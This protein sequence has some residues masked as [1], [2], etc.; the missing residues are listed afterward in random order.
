M[1]LR[2]ELR[3][4]T[5]MKTGRDRPILR[6]PEEVVAQIKSSTVIV[7]LHGVVLELLK[8]ALDAKATR[9]EVSVDFTRG[10]CSVED[11]GLGIAPAEFRPDGGLGKLYCTSKYHAEESYLGCNGTFLASLAAVSLMT[12]ASRH[13]E[14]RSHNMMTFHHSKSIDRQLPAPPQHEMYEKHGTRVTV[15]NLFGN[16]P[17]R[18]KQRAVLAEQRTEHDRL[19]ET[20]QREVVGLLLSWRGQVSMKVRDTD[21][22]TSFS[23]STTAHSSESAEPRSSTLSYMLNVLTQ[24]NY[25]L[26]DDWI[27]WVPTAASTSAIS[28]KGAISLS[29]APSKRVQFISL[30]IRPLSIEFG[31]NELYD[32]VNR[33]FSQ[34][35]FGTVEEDVAV[36]EHEKVR[37]QG[38]KRFKNDGY[39][40]RQ[41]TARKGVDRFPMF[42]LRI[43]SKNS[44]KSGQPGTHFMETDANLQSVM[45]VLREMI[46]QWLSV[47]HFRPRK[48]RS[49]RDA[50]T[51]GNDTESVVQSNVSDRAVA[52]RSRSS[53]SGGSGRRRRKR[54]KPSAVQPTPERTQHRAFAEWSRVKSGKAD[55]F[56]NLRT[57]A[58]S[59]KPQNPTQ[60]PS[61]LTF[62]FATGDPPSPEGFAK[63]DVEPV[64]AG[65]LSGTTS[66][67]HPADEPLFPA[68]KDT[69]ETITWTDPSTKRNFL[70]NA[71][72][73]CVLSHPPSR[74]LSDTSVLPRQGTLKEYNKSLRLTKKPAT[75]GDPLTPWLSGILKTW[76]NPVFKP[77]Q[78]SIQRACHH[79]NQF[80]DQ[81][82]KHRNT[83]EPTR[84]EIEKAFSGCTGS[85]ISKLS[86]TG[87][88]NASILAQ[89]DRK[90]ILAR[91]H[92]TTSD[93]GMPTEAL[94]LIDQHAADERVQVEA[95]FTELCMPPPKRHTH[96]NYRSKLGHQSPVNFTL[97][98]K[99]I[100]ITLTSQ[101][102][103]LFIT[104]AA[105]FASW[106]ILFNIEAPDFTL[107]RQQAVLSVA[108]LPPAVSE[109]CRADV[110]VLTTFLRFAVWKYVDMAKTLPPAGDDSHSDSEPASWVRRLA[111]CPEGLIGLI[112]SRACRSAIMFND[113][114][115]LDECKELVRKLSECVFPFMCAHG[116]PSMVPLVDLG[117]IGNVSS[118]DHGFVGREAVD[119]NEDAKGGFLQAWKKWKADDEE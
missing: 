45:E 10:A 27:S 96:S 101:E 111:T 34:S 76:D 61:G 4:A 69:D 86:K 16:L 21:G 37:R 48:M 70:L 73:G 60:L 50:E 102:Q 119:G 116:R 40:N 23:L 31:N 107:A 17:V 71:R 33:I 35:S 113:E 54:S 83:F 6:L 62:S 103:A 47:H 24:A 52:T 82:H 38:D 59:R 110:Q 64:P 77:A 114:L 109:R 99:P 58:N 92:N 106:G 36:D 65:S 39:T 84:D 7:S 91:V 79:D 72:T 100:R 2:H 75:L 28:I 18:V 115:S 15:R 11:N 88:R 80:D 22:K 98:E 87:L 20:L 26:I 94:V 81:D 89:L 51:A 74:P 90:F 8:N 56:D 49:K 104:H 1:A 63:F 95:L 41:M 55:F 9:I 30:G 67:D 13:H 53:D 118:S 93:T 25:V 85:N 5:D 43:S 29:P 66:L 19:W 3:E 78:K 108:T 46:T 105:R 112:N 44:P 97:L 12:I 14:R 68:D 42:H 117:G 57:G 32:E